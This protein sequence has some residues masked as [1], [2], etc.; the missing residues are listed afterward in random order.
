[1]ARK[2][3]QACTKHSRTYCQ[4]YEC[5]REERDTTDNMGSELGLSIGVG[6]GLPI[7][8]SDGSVGIQVGGFTIDTA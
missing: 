8:P 3:Y 6:N 7:D 5:K 1:M 4:D 2:A